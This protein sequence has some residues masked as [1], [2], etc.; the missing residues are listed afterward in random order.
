MKNSHH[1]SLESKQMG[2]VW[3]SKTVPVD[4]AD[5]HGSQTSLPQPNHPLQGIAFDFLQ[6]LRQRLDGF[7]VNDPKLARLICQA[8]PARCPFERTITL[9]NR[10][11]LRIPPLCKL[12]PVYEELVAVRFRA[13]CYLTDECG[14]DISRYC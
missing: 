9:F 12:N 8:I 3:V 14:E 13:L 10:T 2:F 11:L 5:D 6:P 1:T 4:F 7:K